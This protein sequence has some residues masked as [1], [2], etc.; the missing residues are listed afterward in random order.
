MSGNKRDDVSFVI[1]AAQYI[2]PAQSNLV[3]LKDL[4]HRCGQPMW[5]QDDI[6][7]IME[8]LKHISNVV[9]VMPKRPIAEYDSKFGY[10]GLNAEHRSI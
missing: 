4:A 7:R 1:N 3:Q 10:E 9:G 6:H 2:A 5:I 8:L